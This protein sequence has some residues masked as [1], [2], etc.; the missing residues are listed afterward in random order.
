MKDAKEVV[1]HLTKFYDEFDTM[2]FIAKPG[3]FLTYH[4]GYIKNQNKPY[5]RNLFEIIALSSHSEEDRFVEI[6]RL[7][8]LLF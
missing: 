8:L 7:V 1:G 6:L 2:K 5:A 4:L 3:R